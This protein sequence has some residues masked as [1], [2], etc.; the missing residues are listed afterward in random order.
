M[1]PQHRRLFYED[2]E[3]NFDKITMD[4]VSKFTGR[5][6][7]IS[8]EVK[9]DKDLGWDNIPMIGGINN[10]GCR[11]REWTF[12]FDEQASRNTPTDHSDDALISL[13][14]GSFTLGAEVNDDETWQHHLEQ[15][16]GKKV[17]NFGVGGYGTDQAFFKLE[18]NL[19]RGIKTPITIIGIYSA[20]MARLVSTYRPFYA[21]YGGL[22]LGFKPILQ[23]TDNNTYTKL[24][25]ALSDI[26]ENKY[27]KQAFNKATEDDYFYP[28][29]KLK[30]RMGFPYS[31]TSLRLVKYILFDFERERVLWDLDHKA[32]G[33]LDEVIR[34]FVELSRSERFTP[35]LVFM[36]QDGELAS[37]DSGE[38]SQYENYLDRLSKRYN[39]DE[40][41][42]IDIL[43]EEF[44]A[45][46]FALLGCHPSVYGN[47]V[48]ADA[49]YRALKN[50]SLLPTKNIE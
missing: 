48:I 16:T 27:L 42:L 17:L 47:K 45:P 7:H 37:Y 13:Y 15:H 46:D 24:P 23:E 20:A 41:I 49:V 14:G 21:P 29:N 19:A 6:Q 3:E 28:I 34:R 26:S 39:S 18:R 1:F 25:T 31:L 22:E 44:T 40:L 9:F 2:Y 10:I 30:P 33:R 50:R 4:L 38:P 5:K 36:P 35:V 43:D 11:G 8:A 32:T 12:S